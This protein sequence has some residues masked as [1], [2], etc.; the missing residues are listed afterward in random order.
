VRLAKEAVNGAFESF[1]SDGMADERR[2]FYLLFASQDQ[3]EAW[4]LTL[5]KKTRV[6]RH[7]GTQVPKRLVVQL[8][9]LMTTF[10]DLLKALREL[11]INPSSPVIAHASL[12]SFGEV[13]GGAETVVG[14]MLASYQTLIMPAFTYKVMLIP[15]TGPSGNAAT[16][17]SGKDANR[18]A[19]FFRPEMPVDPL[20][21]A[22]AEALR[23]HPK[24]KRSTHPILSFTGVNAG[25][26]LEAQTIAEPLAPIRVLAGR[27]VGCCC[28]GSITRSI[29]ASI[30]RNAA[31]A[32][33]VRA[34]GVD[35]QRRGRVPR[36]PGCSDGF[37]ALTPRLEV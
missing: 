27:V 2:S 6:E 30:M 3:K 11:E 21:G 24:A 15:E 31:P 13:N 28:S 22:V 17:G 5:T 16:Y 35:L 36:L 32:P 10:R 12:S 9:A 26:V 20:M 1:L 23:L 29:P 14:A 25:P 33:G 19:E 8:P 34:L 18:M 4:L 37:E 7:L